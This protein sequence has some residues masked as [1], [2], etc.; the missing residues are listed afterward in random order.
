[1]EPLIE[2]EMD[3]HFGYPKHALTAVT[4]QWQEQQKVKT[5]LRC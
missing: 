5:M 3:N 1:M 2:G 4:P